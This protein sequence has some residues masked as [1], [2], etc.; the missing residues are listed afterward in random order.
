MIEALV[1]SA[2]EPQIPRCLEAIRK[3]GDLISRT[4]HIDNVVPEYKAF[5]QGISEVSGEWFIKI[6]GDTIL[7]EDAMKKIIDCLNSYNFPKLGV[8]SF[9]LWDSFLGCIIGFTHL[10]KSS[11]VKNMVAVDSII[12][13]RKF[14]N[15]IRS[16]GYRSRKILQTI[17][18]THFDDPDEFQVFRRFYIMA[19]KYPDNNF[20]IKIM[21]K[22]LIEKGD[23]LYSVGLKAIEFSRKKNYYPGS[24]NLKFDREMYDE[25]KK[26][27]I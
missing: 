24:H 7:Y 13:D 10:F 6:D 11:V 22:L 26:E 14:I 21:S 5:N 23:P 12:N 9:G 17:I 3:Q 18:G 4:I 16:M 8:L 1:I 20:V 25:F 27:S 15:K 19:K 2:G